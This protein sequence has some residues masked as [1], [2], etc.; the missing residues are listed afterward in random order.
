MN[1]LQDPTKKTSIT[2]LL[3]PQNASA[4]HSSPLNNSNSPSINHGPTQTPSAFYDSPYTTSP[5]YN[6]RAANWDPTSESSQQKSVS[7]GVQYHHEYPQQSHSAMAA[8]AHP[9]SNG[10]SYPLNPPTTARTRVGHSNGYPAEQPDWQPRPQSHQPSGSHVSYGQA[11]RDERPTLTAE[12]PMSNQESF[13]P[14][15]VPSEIPAPNPV[16]QSTER[17]SVRI[18]AKGTLQEPSQVANNHGYNQSGSGY[19]QQNLYTHPTE[20]NSHLQPPTSIPSSASPQIS[21]VEPSGSSSSSSKRRL[22]DSEATPAPKAKRAKP[23]VKST[24]SESSTPGPSKRGYNAKKRSEAAIISAQNADAFQKAQQGGSDIRQSQGD[25]PG[26]LTTA[27]GS[28]YIPE[29]Q[30]ARCMSNR[31]KKEDFPRCVSCT[32]RWAG[33]TCRFQ[34][35]RYFLRDSQRKLCGVS[36][37]E[38]GHSATPM[39]FPSKWN[40]PLK[41]EQIT[42]IK[43]SI[44]KALFPI[45]VAEQDHLSVSVIVRRPRESDVR[46]TCDT[47][48]TSLFSETFMCRICGREVCNECYQQVRELTEQPTQATPSELT[49]LVMKREKHAHSNPFFL[50]CTKRI[51]HGVSEFIRVTRFS[52]DELQK[53][54]NEMQ[55]IL[56]QDKEKTQASPVPAGRPGTSGLAISNMADSVQPTERHSSTHPVPI[57]PTAASVSSSPDHSF[58]QPSNVSPTVPSQITTYAERDYSAKDFPDPLTS[59]IY[60]DYTPPN[61]SSRISD[62][63][64][65]RAQIIPA[66]LYDNLPDIRHSQVDGPIPMFSCLWRKGLPLLVKNALPRFKLPWTPQSFIERYGDKDCLVVECQSDIVKKVTIKDFFGWFGKYGGRTECW[67]LKDWPPT[68]EFK[69]AFPDLY[70]DFSNAVPVPD[71]VRRD[72]PKMYNSMASSQEPGSKGS[73]RLHMDMADALNI[74]LH[75]EACEDGTEGYA[76]WDLYRAEDSDLIRGFLKKRFGQPSANGAIGQS[77]ANSKSA[78]DKSVASV[79]I[80]LDPIH[81]QQFY[82]DVELRKALFDECGVKSIR[83]Y[84]RPGDGVFIPAGCAHQ[85]ANMSDCMKIAIDFVSPE[86]IDRCEKLTKEFREQ[87]QSKV[88]KE[89]VL[90]LRT[91]MWFAWQSCCIK[92]EEIHNAEPKDRPTDT[93]SSNPTHG[94]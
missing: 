10:Y 19:D 60:D 84:Q 57:H 83:I 89:D 47:C 37:N 48:M 17:A 70:E 1:G 67:K 66:H 6:L 23:K 72:G 77:G 59:P 61:V 85:V 55:K 65:F 86:N 33:D 78:G 87:N 91:M 2:S 14:N 69:A 38:V 11:Q 42:R 45:L 13:T 26:T 82:L 71:Y 30:F 36:F 24:G 74:M 58:T 3:N 15:N 5:V 63:P 12:Y 43:L 88:W 75:A 81:N 79:M 73:T 16:W 49:A 9:Q 46:A 94:G 8:V 76:V 31:Y 20:Y 7:S 4:L 44:A 27:D 80:G 21:T 62:I 35:I 32:R 18:A 41:I 92:E 90:Q 50:A 28:Q 34:G 68:A 29:L 52:N 56:T 25:L 39:E 64:I 93:T 53:S 40:K 54:I 51:E 22:P